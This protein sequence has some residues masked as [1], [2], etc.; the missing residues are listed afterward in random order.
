MNG[1]TASPQHMQGS[2]QGTKPTVYLDAKA[3]ALEAQMRQQHLHRLRRATT[4]APRSK[5]ATLFTVPG[6]G[7]KPGLVQRAADSD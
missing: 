2:K 5:Y 4:T 1:N 7:K 3:I 6:P